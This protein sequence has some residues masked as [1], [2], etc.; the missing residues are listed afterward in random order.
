MS[1]SDVLSLYRRVLR[2]ARSWTA[3]S[4]LPHDTDNERKYIAQ[5]AR[6]LFRQNQQITDPES[7]KR[8]T[9]ECEAR[10]EIGLHYR[11]PYPRPTYLPPMGL[12][13]QKGRKLRAQ[14]R[15]RKQAKP[16]Y[17]LSHDET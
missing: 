17:L 12:A 9:E 1:R 15:L 14:Q 6:T 7:I 2:I 11:N 8:C 13:T 5:E 16:V 3:Q 10:I 4:A